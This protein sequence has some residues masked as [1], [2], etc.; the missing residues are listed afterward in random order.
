MASQADADQLRLKHSGN[1]AVLAALN[2]S[3]PLRLVLQ[4][5]V[6]LELRHRVQCQAD[7]HGQRHPQVLH[8]VLAD[9]REAAERNDLAEVVGMAAAQKTGHR[10][11]VQSAPVAPL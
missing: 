3:R 8:R 7:A 2:E 6:M 9:E 11:S 5:Q 10:A 4:C 1:K